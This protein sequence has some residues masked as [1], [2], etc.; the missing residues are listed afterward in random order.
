MKVS[1]VVLWFFLG[2]ASL[3]LG[4]LMFVVL[5]FGLPL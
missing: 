4:Y 2:L 3:Y 1:D 5:V